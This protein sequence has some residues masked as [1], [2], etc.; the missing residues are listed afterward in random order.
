MLPLP[1]NIGLMLTGYL[2]VMGYLAVGLHLLRRQMPGPERAAGKAERRLAKQLAPGAPRPGWPGLI[3][4]VLGTVVGGYVLLMTVVVGYY[5]GVAQVGGRFLTSAF[6]G[7]ALLVGIA[8]P[9]FFTVSW[10]SERQRR[11]HVSE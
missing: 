3:R 2:L 5:H 10:L 1:L 4:R 11:K 7:C 9:L 6:T 8:L